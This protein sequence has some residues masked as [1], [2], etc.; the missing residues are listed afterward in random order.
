MSGQTEDPTQ[1]IQTKYNEFQKACSMVLPKIDRKQ[2][3]DL[4]L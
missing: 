1:D 3:E 2:V 4:L